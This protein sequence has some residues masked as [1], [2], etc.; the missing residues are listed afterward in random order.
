MR[1]FKLFVLL[2]AG[3]TLLPVHAKVNAADH[4]AFWLWSAVRPQP[5]LAQAESLYVLQG[6]ISEHR[7]HTQF[8]PQGIRTPRLR[9]SRIWLA[10]RVET[11]AWPN[12]ILA[13]ITQQIQRWQKQ[14]NTI[15]GIQIDFDARTLQMQEY[16]TFLQALRQQLPKHYALSIT[17]LLDWSN[18]SSPEVVN[19]LSGIIDEVVVQTYQGRQTIKNYTDYLPRLV[20]LHMPFKVGL[21]QNGEWQAPDYLS[22]SPFFQGYVVFLL[23]DAN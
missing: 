15:V 11:L 12:T 16:V 2:L 14:G 20:K 7:G 21:V 1:L 10:Y 3:S 19:Q 8:I 17:G 23:N 13:T 5:V 18:H 4:H 22:R 9:Q 6:Q